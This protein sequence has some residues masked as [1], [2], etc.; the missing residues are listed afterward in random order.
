MKILLPALLVLLLASCAALRDSLNEPVSEPIV[1]PDGSTLVLEPVA[2]P[3]GLPI[4]TKGDAIISTAGNIIG[5]VTG[6][7]LWGMLAA[8]AASALLGKKTA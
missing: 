8:G 5:A 2:G 7:P 1:L 3:A 6:N 4:E